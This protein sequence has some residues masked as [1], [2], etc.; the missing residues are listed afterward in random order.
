MR[1]RIG[2]DL[3]TKTTKT[4][5][6]ELKGIGTFLLESAAA[7]FLSFKKEKKGVWPLAS[8]KLHKLYKIRIRPLQKSSVADP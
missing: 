6:F 4:N 5:K 1:L 7:D 3:K 2:S 8:A